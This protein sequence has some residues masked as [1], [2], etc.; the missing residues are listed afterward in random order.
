MNGV[1]PSYNYASALYKQTAA[2]AKEAAE[3]KTAAGAAQTTEPEQDVVSL[4]E[5]ALAALEEAEEA[6]RQEEAAAAQEEAEEQLQQEENPTSMLAAT[7]ASFK[8]STSKPSDKTAQLAQRLV[9]AGGAFEV[10]MVISDAA[11]EMLNLRMTA[12]FGEG[13]DKITAQRIIRKLDKLINNATKKI[14]SLGQ[15][16]Q[17]SRQHARAEKNKQE[18]R[19]R[20]I[21]A[22][23]RR[24]V[25]QRK[26][27]ERKW[28]SEA[29]RSV[30]GNQ[31]FTGLPADE[32][33]KL[34][35]ATEAEIAM[36][37]EAQAAAEVAAESGAGTGGGELALDGG[38]VSGEAPA[39]E[40]GGE[41]PV[42]DAGGGVD[43]S[44]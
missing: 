6:Q 2:Q 36:Q 28:L 25:Q 21:K 19:A 44:V 14:D 16:E 15:E 37:A 20:E 9:S 31:P 17:L 34:D 32:S 24:K 4:S 1:N 29:K 13:Q 3:E 22:E 30:E 41:A 27:K 5:E 35:V 38:A 11:K 42:A 33:Q 7:K 10:R 40:G 43:I 23:L 18:E 39:A 12:A 8:L 26:Q